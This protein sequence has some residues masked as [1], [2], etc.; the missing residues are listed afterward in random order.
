MLYEKDTAAGEK[1][2]ISGQMPDSYSPR[3]VEAQWYSWWEKEGFFKPE[4]GRD[5]HADNPK[6]RFVM[7]IPP[8]NVTGSLHIGHALTSAVEDALTRWHRMNGK[9]VLWNPGSD[10]AGIATQV[11]VE[12]KI[13][14]EQGKSR[15]DLGREK[16]IEIVQQWKDE[17]VERIYHQFR[18][19]GCSVDFSRAVFT[20]EPK[21]CRA[22]TEAFCRLHEENL[23]YRANR[24]VNWSCALNSAISDVEVDK[25]DLT[26]RTLLSVPG[27]DKKVEFGVLISFAYKIENSEEEIVVATTRIETM[28]GD[29]A[30]AVHPDDARYKEFHG[31]FVVHPFVERKIPIV[32]DSFVDMEFG[33]GAVK[34]TPAH[35]HNDY[36]VGKRHNLPFINIFQ[37][38]GT[39]S[40]GC[41]RFCGMKRFD[42]RLEVLKDLKKIDLYRGTKDNPMVVPM[43]SRSKD[44]VEPI[45]KPQW[46]VNC[47]E[48]ASDAVKAVREGQLKM[49]PEQ[50]VKTWNWFLENIQDWCISRQLWWGHRIPAYYVSLKGKSNPAGMFIS[51]RFPKKS[52][53]RKSL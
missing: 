36:E 26:G 11:V 19:L 46:Y 23:I 25:I 22:V 12:K 45:L 32:C 10:H 44:I 41:G 1:K 31:K 2:D 42:A 49:I 27:Y 6:G 50:L 34:I 4:Y 51:P 3:Y 28:L 20:M 8:P 33:T 47:K 15:H 9:T 29:T 16:F 48:M 24:L 38:D 7:V 43:C 53:L 39:V 17:K 30:V 37:G 52:T 18:A 40:E 35:D 21:M 13:A 5:P 14:R